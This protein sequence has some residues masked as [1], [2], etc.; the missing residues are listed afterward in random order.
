MNRQSTEPTTV[1]NSWASIG[2]NWRHFGDKEF[3]NIDVLIRYHYL[4][5]VPMGDE[6]GTCL[7]RPIRAPKTRYKESDLEI[8]S[9]LGAGNFGEVFK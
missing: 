5:K 9:Q 4:E 8:I 1:E 7:Q 2:D 6:C 3:E